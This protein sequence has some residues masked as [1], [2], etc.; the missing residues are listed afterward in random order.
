MGTQETPDFYGNIVQVTRTPW[1]VTLHFLRVQVPAGVK[2]GTRINV[3][4]HAQPVARV[5]MPK[6]VAEKLIPALASVVSGSYLKM[7][8][9]EKAHAD[10]NDR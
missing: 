5:T 9:G 8:E 4:E 3:M 10:A 6:D 1:D 2:S 7:Q